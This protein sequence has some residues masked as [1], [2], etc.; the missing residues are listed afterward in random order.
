MGPKRT[1][2]KN[3][4]VGPP[5]ET[6]D[7]PTPQGVGPGVEI[8]REPEA[9]KGKGCCGDQTACRIEQQRDEEAHWRTQNQAGSVVVTACSH[10]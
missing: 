9:T 6:Q 4:T 3:A 1:V 2:W 5:D 10:A 8:W 7:P